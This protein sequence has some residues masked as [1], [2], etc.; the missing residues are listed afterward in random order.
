MPTGK[1]FVRKRDKAN[2]GFT[3]I[4]TDQN[5]SGQSAPIR[6]NP[7]LIKWQLFFV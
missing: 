4:N 3:R 5:P 1:P 2:R 6:A 7:R